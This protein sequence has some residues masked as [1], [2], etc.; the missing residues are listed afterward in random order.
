MMKLACMT[1]PY[2][3]YPLERALQGIAE[4]GYRYVAFGL[5]HAGAE[6][7]D[8][9]DLNSAQ[10]IGSLLE[11][12]GLTPIMLVSTNQIAPGQ[13]LDRARRRFE[14][15]KELGIPELL[16]L[17][18]LSFRNFPHDPYSDEEQQ[19]RNQR[20]IEKFQLLAELAHEYETFITIKPHT[21][22]TATARELSQT[23]AKIGSPWIRGSYDPGNV[24]FYE[25][26]DP[27]EDLP[28]IVSHTQSF[29]AKDHRGARAHRDFPIPGEGDLNFAAMF[30]TLNVA[31]FNGP[32]VVERVDCAD[33]YILEPEE[34]DHRISRARSN[35]V[36]IMMDAGCKFN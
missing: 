3:K 2:A 8:E 31:A 27:A 5:P 35:L 4:A 22:N 7:P 36:K 10:K 9:D 6:S 34:I 32:V 12:F 14:F 11:S 16:S 23:L 15:A 29:V 20:F 13:P 30:R 24:H 19:A 28:L 1:L 18:T 26:I 33:T 21:G 25:E 17:G